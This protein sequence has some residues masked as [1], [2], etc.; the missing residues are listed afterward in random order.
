MKNAWKIFTMLVVAAVI[1]GCSNSKE[2]TS[3]LPNGTLTIPIITDV[4]AE[5]KKANTKANEPDQSYEE[6][7]DIIE[8]V[9]RESLCRGLCGKLHLVTENTVRHEDQELELTIWYDGDYS[10]MSGEY[11][12]EHTSAPEKAEAYSIDKYQVT[13]GD[14][15]AFVY[16]RIGAGEWEL[17]M[18]DPGREFTS[19]RTILDVSD[20]VVEEQEGETIITG[21]LA[22]GSIP[23]FLGQYIN[24]DKW[25]VTFCAALDNDTEMLIGMDI[26]IDVTP[27]DDTEITELT[28]HLEPKS[29][30]VVIPEEAM[31]ARA[32]L[33]DVGDYAEEGEACPLRI[34]LGKTMIEKEMPLIQMNED[35]VTGIAEVDGEMFTVSFSDSGIPAHRESDLN[36]IVPLMRSQTFI[37]ASEDEERFY[38][39]SHDDN[40]A[41][42]LMDVGGECF[43]R[44]DVEGD[45]KKAIGI[46][47]SC[48]Q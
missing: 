41:T 29:K 37:M 34:Q 2:N 48:R 45:G 10:Y 27:T 42:V 47:L 35:C 23:R 22:N 14:E 32:R 25:T 36:A 5:T 33:L 20:C 18:V 44:V 26:Y 6:E 3:A 7:P 12:F 8:D 15:T 21:T 31:Q 28:Y 46:A 9:M 16:S 38:I 39:G 40:G 30:S 43:L 19:R 4:D 17:G 13:E 1:M 24:A 11:R